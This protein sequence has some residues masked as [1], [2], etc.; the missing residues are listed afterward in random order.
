ML[1]NEGQVAFITGAAAGIG[2]AIAQKFAVLGASVI[3][4]DLNVAGAEA[5]VASLANPTGKQKHAAI[6]LNV[7]KKDDCQAA[8]AWVKENYGSIDILMNNAG[9][10]SMRHLV[11]LTEEEW[12]FNFNVNSKG[13]FLVTQA[14]APLLKD[15]GR[16]VNTCSMAA[17]K[18]DPTLPHYTASKFAVLGLTKAAA[19]EFAARNITVNCVCPGFVKTEM[20]DR[21]IVWEAELRGVTPE[22]VRQGYIDKTP[23]GRLCYPED[24]ADVVGFLVSPEAKFLTGE[25]INVAGGANLT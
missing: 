25:A 7:T 10:S 16:I 21:E 24:V 15:G 23:L 6:K 5:T 20:Q 18:A 3:V 2:R 13:V 8:M 12:D 19:L 11:D 4:A 9:V 14:A 22:E 17:V 1:Q